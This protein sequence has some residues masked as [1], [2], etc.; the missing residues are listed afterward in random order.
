MEGFREGCRGGLV[1]IVGPQ[2]SRSLRLTAAAG[3][4]ATLQFRSKCPI[5]GPAISEAITA[6]SAL[7]GLSIEQFFWVLPRAAA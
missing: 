3:R 7:P 1:M 5:A 6:R 2:L 4:A